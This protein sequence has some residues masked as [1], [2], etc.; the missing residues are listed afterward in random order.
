M[1]QL[2]IEALGPVTGGYDGS[3]NASLLPENKFADGMNISI[4]GGFA[5]TR[6][7]FVAQTIA[8]MPATD[9]QGSGVWSLDAGDRL[10][11]VAGGVVYAIELDTMVLTTIAGGALL[12]SSAQC[13]VEQADRY[14]I[15][16]DGVSEPVILIDESGTARQFSYA[17]DASYG[18]PSNDGYDASTDADFVAAPASQS[19]PTGTNMAY[20]MGRLHV[21]PRYV[22][23]GTDT[24]KPYFISGDIVKPSRPA[25][26]L[27]FKETQYLTGGGAHGMPVEMGFINGLSMM[28]NSQQGT[29]FGDLFAFGR[30]GLSAFAVSIPRSEWTNSNIAQ[31]LF[32]GS[33]TKSPWSIIPANN[34]I[35]FRALDGLRMVSYTAQQQWQSGSLFNSPISTEVRKYMDDSDYLQYVSSAFVDNHHLTTCEGTS[36]RY[37]KGMVHM[38]VGSMVNLGTPMT[39]PAYTGVWTG[40][41]FGQVLTAR[42]GDRRVAMAFAEGIKV[43][44]IDDDVDADNG[45]T[46]ITSRIVTRAYNYQD[47]IVRKKLQFV[48]LWVSDLTRDT[49]V[50]VYARPYGYPYWMELATKTLQVGESGAAQMRQRL[51]F[52]LDA[53]TDSCDPVSG[54]P[55]YSAAEFQ[56][57]IEWTGHMQLDRAAFVAEVVGEAPPDQCSE[58]AAVELIAGALTGVSLDSF[59]YTID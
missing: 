5:R 29:G 22:P 45:D 8:G 49:S 50:T 54:R 12:D 7:A 48:D 11:F 34:D 3:L 4:R 55:L 39:G 14:A 33:G 16:Q 56:F 43:Y 40:D 25:D 41:N 52:G 9:F 59:S 15:I 28:R 13:F 38:D 27:R 47:F 46:D 42:V 37:F 1:G 36:D 53:A 21:V 20:I 2:M 19:L 58:T 35:I 10:V 23:G 26:C 18:D 31:G 6:P 57:A 24:G 30:N 51:R 17:A 44:I 32:V